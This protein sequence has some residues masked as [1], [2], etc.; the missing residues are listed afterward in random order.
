MKLA[1][2][3]YVTETEYLAHEV[4]SPV[5]HE[6]VAGRIHAMTG[7]SLRH[8]VIAGNIFALLRNHLR[9]SPCR[10]FI[11]DTKLRVAKTHS[12][13]Y[14][15]VLVTCDPQHL[16]VGPADQVVDNP[17]LIV[18]VL[19]ESTAATDRR[20]KLQAYRSL[21]TLLEYVLVSQ[22]EALIEIHRRSGDIGWQLATLTAGDPVELKSV[23]LLTDFAAIYEESGLALQPGSD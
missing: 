20:E 12:I 5:R 16:S 9:G 8:N 3:I 2:D 19:S 13:Y 4:R 22:D 1:D 14:P 7:A 23:E 11:A 6:Y 15:D 10:A 17:R 18:E 21:P